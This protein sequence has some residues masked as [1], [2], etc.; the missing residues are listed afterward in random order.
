MVRYQPKIVDKARELRKQNLSFQEIGKILNIPSSTIRHWCYDLEIDRHE[1]L[2][3]NNELRRNVIKEAGLKYVPSLKKL[4]AG[5]SQFAAALLY[6][7]EGCKYPATSVMAFVNSDPR[8]VRTFIT[9]L[10]KGFELEEEKFRVHL[11]I[12][13][14]HD[15]E[16]II[17]FWSSLL[18]IS[19]DHFY[20]PTITPPRGK[21]RRQNYLGTCSLRYQDFKL[22]LKLLG[23]FEKFC[24]GEVA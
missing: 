18:N 1:S 15:I 19:I 22:Q 6:G 4:S 2:R 3:L 17:H 8:L 14:Y 12:H 10:R 7:C 9:L 16:E 20:K 23:I 13:D 11:Q 24:S 5:E 21:M